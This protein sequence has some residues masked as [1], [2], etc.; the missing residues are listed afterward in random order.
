[1][2][3]YH[4]LCPHCGHAFLEGTGFTKCPQ[5]QVPLLEAGPAFTAELRKLPDHVD[6][7]ALVRDAIAE[8]QPEED[9]AA[10]LERAVQR[11]FP[12]SAD[13]LYRL[14]SELLATQQRLRG[15][16][17]QAAAEEM[18]KSQ[19]ELQLGPDGAPRVRT[20][21]PVV[22]REINLGVFSNVDSEEL[23]KQF[24][25]ALKSGKLLS[26]VQLTLPKIKFKTGCLP[27]LLIGILVLLGAM[28]LRG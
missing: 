9:I 19:S 6:L 7:A 28:A 15:L 21:F 26:D 8:Q 18:A 14:I 10:A 27:R 22:H 4:F 12:E 13:G 24:E 11:G 5:C 20:I 16:T 23:Q 1:M 25:Q 3:S 2:T 17:L